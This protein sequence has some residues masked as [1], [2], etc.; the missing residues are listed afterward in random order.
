MI[1]ERRSRGSR[2]HLAKV[3]TAKC[4]S[5]KSRAHNDDDGNFENTFFPLEI[6]HNHLTNILGHQ[7][8]P[9]RTPL[10]RSALDYGARDRPP[11]AGIL[12]GSYARHS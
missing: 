5:V 3:T 8:A 2:R 7:L 6:S 1:V 10:G 9:I 11:L 4:R 12:I